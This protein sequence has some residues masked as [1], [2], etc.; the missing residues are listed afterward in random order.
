MVDGW[1]GVEDEKTGG[2]ENE[3][4]VSGERPD[5]APEIRLRSEAMAGQAG[6]V[7]GMKCQGIDEAIPSKTAYVSSEGFVVSRVTRTMAHGQG[8]EIFD[9]RTRQPISPEVARSQALDSRV[10]G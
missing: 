3:R 5:T 1:K 9:M 8:V 6:A 10:C 2:R 7:P 4:D